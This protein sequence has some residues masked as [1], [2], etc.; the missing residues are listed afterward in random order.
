MVNILFG[1]RINMQGV[2]IVFVWQMVDSGSCNEPDSQP[3][4]DLITHSGPRR[5]DDRCQEPLS[6]PQGVTNHIITIPH[7]RLE[8]EGEH[9]A[10]VV[11][12]FRAVT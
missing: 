7:A 12:A 1:R 4:R 3:L 9:P 5:F 8:L 11:L 10:V 6:P 2:R